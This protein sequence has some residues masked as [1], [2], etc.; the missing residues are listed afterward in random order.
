MNRPHAY[1]TTSLILC[2]IHDDGEIKIE[3]YGKNTIESPQNF[4]QNN[5]NVDNRQ[6]LLSTFF[7]ETFL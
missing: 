1:I 4:T 6:T 2:I 3:K 5:V 7:L